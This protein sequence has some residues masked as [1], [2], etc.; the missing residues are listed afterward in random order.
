MMNQ[1]FD[2]EMF[3]IYLLVQNDVSA[4][5]VLAFPCEGNVVL[6]IRVF[7]DKYLRIEYFPS[8]C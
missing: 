3:R 1:F 8:S 5:C 2:L 4:I 7:G 6:N